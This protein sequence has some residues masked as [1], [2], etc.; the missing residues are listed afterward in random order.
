MEYFW[1]TF[2]QPTLIGTKSKI[3]YSYGYI[4]KQSTQYNNKRYMLTGSFCCESFF[5]Y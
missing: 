1:K 5:V 2:H 4:K 3:N